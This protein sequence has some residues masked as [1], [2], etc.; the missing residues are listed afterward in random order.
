MFSVLTRATQHLPVISLL[1]GLV[2]FLTA[3]RAHCLP[4]R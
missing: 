1:A 4:P 3:A 2:L